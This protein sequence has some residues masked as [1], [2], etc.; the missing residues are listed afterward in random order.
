MQTIGTG[1]ERMESL[2][3]DDIDSIRPLEVV[4]VHTLIYEYDSHKHRRFRVRLPRHL[5]ENMPLVDFAGWIHDDT[6]QR[7]CSFFDRL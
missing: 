1:E 4:I 6:T 5:L 7:Y 3:V 2:L